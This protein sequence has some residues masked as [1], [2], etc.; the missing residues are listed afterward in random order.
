[1]STIR[2]NILKID[3]QINQKELILRTSFVPEAIEIY[4]FS[5]DNKTMMYKFESGRYG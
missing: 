3:E 4:T 1:M 2:S 5:I